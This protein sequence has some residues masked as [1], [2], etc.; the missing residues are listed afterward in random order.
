[1]TFFKKIS[2]LIF[3]STFL[4]PSFASAD[5]KSTI[6]EL[7]PLC[8]EKEDCL[9][10]REFYGVTG[11]TEQ[12]KGCIEENPCK[13]E[14]WCKCLP[15]GRTDTSIAIGGKTSFIHMGDY[16]MVVFNY[17]LMIAGILAVLVIIV[18]GLQWLTSGGNSD[19]IGRAKKRL[20]GALV[21]LFLAYGSFF[22]LGQINPALT[23]L[24]L[25]Q[26]WMLKPQELMPTFCSE[27]KDDEIKLALVANYDNQLSIIS[28]SSSS[29]E[30]KYTYAEAKADT[31]PITESTNKMNWFKCGTRFLAEDGGSI[32]CFGDFCAPIVSGGTYARMCTPNGTGNQKYICEKGNIAGN[33]VLS[34]LAAKEFSGCLAK[35][36]FGLEGW[37]E[38][39]IR[40]VGGPVFVCNY[41]APSKPGTTISVPHEHVSGSGGTAKDNGSKWSYIISVSNE[42]LADGYKYC[43][44]RGGVYGIVMKAF[45]NEAC[46]ADS[47]SDSHYI[48]KNGQDLGNHGFFIEKAGAWKINKNHFFTYEE[49]KQGIRLNIDASKIYD[50]DDDS[51]TEYKKA[52]YYNLK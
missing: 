6:P 37:E 9:K 49:V 47:N 14:G 33:I 34:G 5:L 44:T 42:K 22:I 25:P 23:N 13:T 2:L 26:V 21:G 45:M 12:A 48:G 40:S 17:A 4:I 11:T 3:L 1:M 36:F 51:E 8:W 41:K 24:R 20:G 10:Q 35:T 7:N 52:G 15:A 39:P 46:T 28:A 18:A 30:Y 43:E 16:M 29:K 32:A 27:L 38:K 50:I 31:T 19:T